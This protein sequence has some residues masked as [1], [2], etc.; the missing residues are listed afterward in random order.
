MKNL[1]TLS[2]PSILL[3]VA[4]LATGCHKT[5]KTT[6][7]TNGMGPAQTAGKTVDDAG[8]NA[9]QATREGAARTEAAADRAGD[10]A[11]DAAQ[12]AGDK[13]S[14]AAARTDAAARDAGQ[15]IKQG[16]SNATDAAGR[17]LEHAGKKM[18]DASK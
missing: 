3:A 2:I 1:K 12:R 7:E 13:M 4:V 16:A 6:V 9:A 14:D 11:R 5:E 8:A 18:Q 17:G 10:N 15:D